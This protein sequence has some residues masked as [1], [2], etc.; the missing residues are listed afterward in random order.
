MNWAT[1]IAE[2]GG[3]GAL[4]SALINLTQG[5]RQAHLDLQ[6]QKREDN[7]KDVTEENK[8]IYVK[9]DKIS[10]S[11]LGAWVH[12]LIV[13]VAMFIISAPVWGPLL[14]ILTWGKVTIGVTWYWPTN[15]SFFL[16][17]WDKLKEFYFGP[18][19]PTVTIGVLPIH[20]SMTLN[21]MGFYFVNRIFK[22]K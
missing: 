9:L 16:F 19:N 17:E 14:T 18:E 20:I 7:R 21:I 22:R 15:R 4:L 11:D 6:K 10:S 1:I 13:S 5:Y 8:D 3:G 2:L 12:R